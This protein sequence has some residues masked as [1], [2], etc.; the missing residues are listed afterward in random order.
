[1]EFVFVIIHSVIPTVEPTDSSEGTGGQM[2]SSS[3]P[4][5]S[6]FLFFTYTHAHVHTYKRTHAHTHTYT[7]TNTYTNAHAFSISFL[8]DN[9]VT[10]PS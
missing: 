10:Y 5:L 2:T 1:M 8:V 9:T 3:Q 4:G 6:A 7:N